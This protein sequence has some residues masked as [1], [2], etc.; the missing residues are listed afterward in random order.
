MED[1]L[2]FGELSITPKVFETIVQKA[3]EDVEGVASVGVPAPTSASLFSL[4]GA[5][6]QQQTPA[7]GVRVR[8]GKLEVAV[9]VTAFFGYPF[10]TL[11]K[12]V[13]T[14][15][16]TM[17]ETLTSICVASVDVFIDALAFPKE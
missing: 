1:E 9:H 17:V 16:A 13:R 3:V 8:Q 6:P 5:A 14:A 11:T 4:F 7:V 12:Q 10:K 15:V 2:E